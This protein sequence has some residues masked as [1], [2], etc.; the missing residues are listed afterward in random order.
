MELQ[1][2]KADRTM[3]EDLINTV[4]RLAPH[5]E[6][7]HHIPGRIRL[8]ISLS[9]LSLLDA[10]GISGTIQEIPGVMSQR[11]NLSARSVLIEYDRKLIPYDLWELLGQIRCRPELGPVASELMEILWR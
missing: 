2:A 3:P 4:V 5:V 9:A 6:I 10:T 11:I 7:C 1:M 8:K